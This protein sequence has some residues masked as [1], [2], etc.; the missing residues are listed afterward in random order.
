MKFNSHTTLLVPRTNPH[1]PNGFALVV[2]LSLMAFVLLLLLSIV[3]F[4][5]VEQANSA[6]TKTVTLARQNAII[7][8]QVA[9]G[10]LQ[11]QLGADQRISASAQMLDK[12]LPDNA[13][14]SNWTG[15]WD[16][17]E[18]ND[19]GSNNPNYGSNLGW[20]ISGYDTID[21]ADTMPSISN[22]L[23]AD[24]TPQ[25]PDTHVVLVGGGT[26]DPANVDDFVAAQ[27]VAVAQKGEYAYWVADEG[28]KADIN[29]SSRAERGENLYP[30]VS[31]D[32][33]TR[34]ELSA[35]PRNN[36]SAL[37]GLETFNLENNQ[38]LAN[39]LELTSNARNLILTDPSLNGNNS[40]WRDALQQNFH[41]I[42]F[43]TVTLQTN[44]REGGLKKDL[45]L[46][47]EMKDDDFAR[48]PYS[49]ETSEPE[50]SN[51]ERLPPTDG[52]D[53]IDPVT[54]D[55]VSYLFKEP[56]PERGAAAF[57]RGPTW[58]KLRDFYRSYK[59]VT[60]NDAQPTVAMRPFGP[61]AKDLGNN[62]GEKGYYWTLE[63]D[64]GG[65]VK[66]KPN[67]NYVNTTVTT[68]TGH[69]GEKVTRLTENAIMPVMNRVIYVFSLYA[70]SNVPEYKYV[71]E[72][73]LL[74]GGD[75]APAGGEF[76]AT[77]GTTNAI[78][79]VIEP[80]VCLWNPYNVAIE[81]KGGIKIQTDGAFGYLFSLAP[82]SLTSQGKHLPSYQA[83]GGNGAA[84]NDLDKDILSVPQITCELAAMKRV[85]QNG[86]F[87]SID[88]IIGD[89]NSTIKL[90]PGEVHFFTDP[91]SSPTPFSNLINVPDDNTGA[92]QLTSGLNKK[93]GIILGRRNNNFND[94]ANNSIIHQISTNDATPMEL[95][96]L[97]WTGFSKSNWGDLT[98]RTSS[99][100]TTTMAYVPESELSSGG[101]LKKTDTT[102]QNIFI[103][104]TGP[105]KNN[106]VQPL[107]HLLYGEDGTAGPFPLLVN[108]SAITSYPNKKMPFLYIGSYQNPVLPNLDLVP[109]PSEFIGSMSPF[110]GNVD[111]QFSHGVNSTPYS[112]QMGPM[113]NYTDI[114]GLNDRGFFGEGYSSA[115]ESHIVVS[116]IP[117]YPLR[118]LASMQHVH[119]ADSA[120]MP[121]QAIG[122]S[123]PNGAIQLNKTVGVSGA[124]YTQYDLSYLANEAIFDDYFFSSLTPNMNLTSDVTEID[125]PPTTLANIVET[126]NN[127][128]SLPELSNERFRYIGPASAVDSAP[129]AAS[130]TQFVQDL[131]NIDG[132]SKTAAYFGVKGGF[133]VNSL[134][135]D[136]WDAFLASTLGIDYTYLD[137]LTGYATEINDDLTIFPRATLPNGSS[138]E[139]WRGPKGL[140]VT[141]RR[142]L[143]QAI[144]DE[145]KERGPFLSLAEFV[146]R[147]LELTENGKKGVIQAAIDSL[148]VNDAFLYEE[149]Y[150]DAKNNYF[151]KENVTAKTGVGLPQYL[152]QA[153]VLTPL[154]PYLSARSDTFVIRSYGSAKNNG[155]VDAEAVLEAVVYRVPKFVEGES[156]AAHIQPSRLSSEINKQFGRRFVV[157]S[158][159]WLSKDEI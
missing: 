148:D 79:L 91:N 57:L 83:S 133:N 117:T 115:S 54:N 94:P 85:M 74:S 101:S 47:F 13:P 102:L 20:L 26:V 65:D 111:A 8:L 18:F 84:F 44:T 128:Q 1:T 135:V 64:M 138:S 151:K 156:D 96:F 116:E 21:Y 95:N 108:P 100:F 15:V 50:F 141:Q 69:T 72:D 41:N 88:L 121:G 112:Y 126:A 49:G 130:T 146:N 119:I 92:I 123:W 31:E 30:G 77:G 24:G 68:K 98:W 107:H 80:I 23:K 29:L 118:S 142:A 73:E 45:S 19:D 52:T 125:D 139:S 27:K 34:L 99:N 39:D 58:H 10:N 114:Q 149:A 38:S 145:I 137:P 97:P 62:G 76:E 67:D 42:S 153:D 32:V 140:D 155:K 150:M 105:K 51:W 2:A 87:G 154:A 16:T 82:T 22:P 89:K 46:L 12:T 134:S 109:S 136:A 103:G 17:K 113:S 143:A 147:K 28:R 158:T 59:G 110:S 124:R 131:S 3:T 61:S 60:E 33:R 86:Y 93:G 9:L 106:T 7:G 43:N 104:L 25:N 56:V 144:V 129:N 70:D 37:A 66:A 90:E 36:A 35:P 81:F 11:K 4:I 48:T 132:F 71:A 157:V 159:R 152:T 78:S 63:A 75:T 14:T 40:L 122:N 5:K 6:Q 120:Y 55:Q 127:T 53:Y